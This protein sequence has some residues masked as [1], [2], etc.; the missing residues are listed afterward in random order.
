MLDAVT[1][2]AMVV[3]AVSILLQVYRLIIGPTIPDRAVALDTMGVHA[4]A[5]IVLYSIKVNSLAFLDSALVIAILSFLTTVV[6]AKFLV[7]GDIVDRDRN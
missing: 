5:L 3:L 7:R 4:I 1:S 6:I 2:F